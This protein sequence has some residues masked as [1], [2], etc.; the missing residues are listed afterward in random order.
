MKV[1]T[2]EL[3]KV[4]DKCQDFALDGRLQPLQRA[5]FRSL[6]KRLRGSLVNLLSARF[7]EGTPAV[8]TANSELS[9]VNSQIAS[10]TIALA[11]IAQTVSDI[12]KLVGTLDGLL[13]IAVS[14]V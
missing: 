9:R 7:D 6:A 4:I 13:S 12:S 1:D 3:V 14:F 2:T 11:N 5:E 10:Q 8:L